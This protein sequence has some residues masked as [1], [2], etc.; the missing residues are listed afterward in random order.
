MAPWN[1]SKGQ[2]KTLVINFTANQKPS[3]ST[4][5]A[6]LLNLFFW[7]NQRKVHPNIIIS[8]MAQFFCYLCKL[9]FS[10]GA[11]WNTRLFPEPVGANIK[12]S[13][14]LANPSTLSFDYC[15]FVEGSSRFVYVPFLS[16]LPCLHFKAKCLPE[17]WPVKYSA[18]QVR[19]VC[20]PTDHLTA[21]NWKQALRK[22]TY[23]LLAFQ[24]LPITTDALLCILRMY[25]DISSVKTNQEIM[26]FKDKKNYIFT[27]IEPFRSKN[28]GE[29][30]TN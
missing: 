6:S 14:S 12:K 22:S 9:M 13:R 17:N 15:N 1:Q 5:P 28:F 29:N 18:L 24:C 11:M 21:R 19:K 26:I 23:W 16:F 2:L 7:W 20:F 30:Q 3:Y 4:K 27:H 8:I 10:N 25:W